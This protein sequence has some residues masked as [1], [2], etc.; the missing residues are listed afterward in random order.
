MGLIHDASYFTEE[1]VKMRAKQHRFPNNLAVELF[2][3]DCEIAAQLQTQSQSLI[4][5]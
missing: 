4:L 3:W 1:S 5:N 2:L